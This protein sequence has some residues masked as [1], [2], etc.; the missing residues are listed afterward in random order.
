MTAMRWKPDFDQTAARFEAWWHGEIT[1]RPPVTVT[2]KP[3]R[4]YAGPVSQHA[5]AKDRWLDVQFQVEHG[6][7]LLEQHDY[8]GDAFPRLYA[9]VG[10]EITAALFGVDIHYLDERTGWADPVV[11]SLDQWQNI[12]DATPDFDNGYWRAIQRMTQLAIEA[13]DGRYVVGMTDLHG[14]YD[15]LSAL[16]EP[17]DLCMDLLD[18]PELIR[19][20]GAHVSAAFVEA[21]ENCYRQVADAGFGSTTW[22]PIYHDGPAYLPSCD[23][24]CMVS[25]QMA[26]DLILPDIETEIKAMART[27]FHL[28][29]PE[30]LGHLDALLELPQLNAVQWVYGAGNGPALRWIDVYRR[31]REA[32]K[33]IEVHAKDPA[34]ALHVIE[35][36]GAAGVWL[37]LIDPFDDAAS[38]EAFIE[39]VASRARR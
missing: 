17:Q 4:P 21:F 33:S 27:L 36:L 1:D 11:H 9:N 25:P 5:N 16:R 22:C 31:I 13:C 28:D 35:Q 6:I 3:S 20:V 34:D 18:D 26:R 2:V 32:G 15:I 7:A 8:V 24:W 38:A 30:A 10:P 14:N 23:F 29:G 39:Q 19:R 12:L 37:H